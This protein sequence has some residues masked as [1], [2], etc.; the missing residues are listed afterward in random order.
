MKSNNKYKWTMIIV[1]ILL[2]CLIFQWI[3]YLVANDYIREG[4]RDLGS[5]STSH[6]VNLPLTT[7]YS[8]KNMCGPPSRCSISGQQCTSDIDCP[9]CQPHV[10][11]LKS[12]NKYV[13]GDN[14]AGKLTFGTTPRY[15]PLTTDIGTQARIITKNKFAKPPQPD[16]G[17]NTW[18]E[19]FKKTNKLYDNTFQPPNL[20]FM[21]TYDKRYSLSG[22]FIENGP[23]ASN[24]YFS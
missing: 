11:P 10:P 21:P 2:L 4:L 13:P 22:E 18:I 6:T 12:N 5:S 3:N 24:A 17:I 9:G 1:C 20:E 14:D 15:S 8:C 23:L 7:T 19:D 16:L